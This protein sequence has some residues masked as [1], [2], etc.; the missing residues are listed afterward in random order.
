MNESSGSWGSIPR[1]L[2]KALLLVLLLTKKRKGDAF[3]SDSVETHTNTGSM[4]I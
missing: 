3:D 2:N 1:K 4:E